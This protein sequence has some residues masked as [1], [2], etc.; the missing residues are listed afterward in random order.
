MQGLS[1]Y[2]I[3]TGLFFCLLRS[4]PGFPLQRHLMAHDGYWSSSVMS[5]VEKEGEKEKRK[6]IHFLSDLIWF[7]SFCKLHITLLILWPEFGLWPYQ[8]TRTSGK[9]NFFSFVFISWRL[10]TSQH[11]SGFCH[12]LTWIIHGVTC[13]PHPDPPSHLPLHQIPL[14]LPVHQAQAPVSCIPPGPVIRFTIDNI[15]AV[16]SKHPTLALSHRV[17]KS[18]LYICV[19][20]SVLHIGLSLPSF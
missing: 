7:K 15:H 14:G 2:Y 16:L 10:V 18:V 13:I 5:T 9:C 6:R 3:I 11:C 1:L 19:S 17:Q 20:F 12:T 8:A 4:A